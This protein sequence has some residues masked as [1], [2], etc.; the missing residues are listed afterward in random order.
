MNKKSWEV[1]TNQTFN[2]N[3]CLVYLLCKEWI[4]NQRYHW[5]ITGANKNI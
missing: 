5:S 3:F 4:R 2:K 1:L